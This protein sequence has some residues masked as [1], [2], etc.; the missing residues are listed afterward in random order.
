V[1]N[2][3]QKS[4]TSYE[5]AAASCKAKVEAIRREC[6]RLNQKYYDRMFDLPYNDALLS[7]NST[8]NPMSLQG[9]RGVGSVK[10]V[11]D[12][13]EDPEFFVDGATAQDVRQGINGDCWFLAAITALGGKQELIERLCVARDE[14]V[15]VYGFV[16]FRGV[17]MSRCGLTLVLGL[18]V[19]MLTI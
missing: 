8:E 7:L 3:R 18:S 1:A 9:L 4:T 15:G 12:I 5:E 14:Q 16:F 11:E 2:S 6:R 13:Y 19:S 10:R 17:Y